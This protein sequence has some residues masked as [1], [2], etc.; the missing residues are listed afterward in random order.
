MPS[1]SPACHIIP[2]YLRSYQIFPKSRCK[3]INHLR[4]VALFSFSPSSLSSAVSSSSVEE[5]YLQGIP[6]FKNG[7]TLPKTL[8]KSKTPIPPPPHP[9]LTLL[10]Q[11]IK[12]RA[13]SAQEG[14]AGIAGGAKGSH[15]DY[16]NC[17]SPG[18]SFQHHLYDE[19][20]T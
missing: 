18:Q 16:W 20:W 2:L 6:P 11:E 3:P 7:D 10:S 9:H 17:T 15:E 8:S 19:G 13:Q 5:L 1:P 14:R 4:K 12:N